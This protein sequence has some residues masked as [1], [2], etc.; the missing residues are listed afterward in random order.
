MADTREMID[1]VKMGNI[2]NALE[3][4]VRLGLDALPALEIMLTSELPIREIENYEAVLKALL[5]HVFIN[6]VSGSEARRIAQF[7]KNIQFI[8]KYKSYAIKS[9]SPLGYA[10]FFQK[11]NQGFSFQRHVTHKTEVF[12]I[13]EPMHGGYVFL[14]TYDD[15]A[16]IYEPDSF[17]AWMIGKPDDQYERFRI[18]P[19]PGDV[20][21][22]DKLNVVHTVIGCILEEFATVSTDMVDRLHDQNQGHIIPAEFNR[23]FVADNLAKL[24]VPSSRRS[25]DIVTHAA[26]MLSPE[27]QPG[28]RVTRLSCNDMKIAWHEI[29]PDSKTNSVNSEEDAISLYIAR[30][31]ARLAIG[32][33]KELKS[34]NPTT[35]P[36]QTGDLFMVPPGI[37]YFFINDANSQLLVSEHRLPYEIAFI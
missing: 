26:S 31:N 20:F 14:C 19:Q 22:I 17:A 8:C 2:E 9:A 27:P 33:P 12:H 11:P 36:A 5:Q 29:E 37:S 15:W 1:S 13:L 34:D 10:I 32:E 18:Y 4:V 21:V 28:G 3:T 16:A 24:H 23:E 25:I 7:Q 35:I 6:G 30:G